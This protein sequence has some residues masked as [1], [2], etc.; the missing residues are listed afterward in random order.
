[1]TCTWQALRTYGVPA[2]MILVLVAVLF[3]VSLPRDSRSPVLSAEKHQAAVVVETLA[4]QMNETTIANWQLPPSTRQSVPLV[5]RANP[6]DPQTNTLYLYDW[7]EH[8][9]RSV[10]TNVK[11]YGGLIHCGEQDPLPSPD[12]LY[13]AYVDRDNTVYILS[14]ETL[15]KKAVYQANKYALLYLHAWSSDS[16]TLVFCQQP[17]IGEDHGFVPLP[18]VEEMP[19]RYYFFDTTSGMLKNIPAAAQVA[20]GSFIDTE[21]I[22]AYVSLPPSLE[23]VKTALLI[24]TLSSNQ[25][26]FDQKLGLTVSSST[27]TYDPE[28]SSSLD[29][30]VVTYT[31]ATLGSDHFVNP[32]PGL[33]LRGESSV[34]MVNTDAQTRTVLDQGSFAQYQPSYISPRGSKIAYEEII[35]N[36]SDVIWIYDTVTG[37]KQAKSYDASRPLRWLDEDTLLF[38]TYGPKSE[39]TF[40]TLTVTSGITRNVF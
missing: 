37:Q 16:R 40:R 39:E 27:S 7:K 35:R 26:L 15:E 21:N 11:S 10:D 29:G 31:L 3:I 20:L 19:P 34:M 33:K 18:P 8:A 4:S 28:Y 14:H 23:T 2:A 25:K 12:F 5:V 17:Q 9:S 13:T 22:I 38:V 32:P 30:S 6:S 36:G 1:M 24:D